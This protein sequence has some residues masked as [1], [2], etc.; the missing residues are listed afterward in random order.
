[1]KAQLQNMEHQLEALIDGLRFD[2]GE[3]DIMVEERDALDKI[4][5]S[6]ANQSKTAVLNEVNRFEGDMRRGFQQQAQENYRLGT[7][8]RNQL[9]ERT[10]LDNELMKVGKKLE[11]LE[12][13]VG[14]SLIIK[15]SCQF[16]PPC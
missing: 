9:N 1:M 16:G 15:D 14:K 5:C 2:K 8:V 4:Y 3:I 11:E 6:K 13:V 10:D 12:M 7:E